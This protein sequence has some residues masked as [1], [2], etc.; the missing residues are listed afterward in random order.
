[1]SYPFQCYEEITHQGEAWDN[2]LNMVLSHEDE[3][4][5]FWEEREPTEV[6]F[7]GC[8]SPFYAGTSAARFWQATLGIPV[9]AV[10]CNE[11][12]QFSDS[13][14]AKGGR[15]ILVVLSRSGRTTEALWAVENFNKQYPDRSILITP[16]ENTPL[17]RLTKLNLISPKGDDEALPQ[18]RSVSSMY[19]SALAVG[20]ILGSSAGELSNLKQA[21]ASVD[22]ILPVVE[23]ALH[24]LLESKEFNRVFFLGAGPLDGIAREATLKVM[25][26]SFTD[27]FYY[28]FLESRHGPR[29][30]LDEQTLVVGMFS[31]TGLNYEAQVMQEYTQNFGVTSLAIVPTR[32]W[33]TGKVTQT[34][35]VDLALGDYLQ[36][37]IYLPV[38]QMVAFITA[39]NKGINPDLSKN[40]T[41]FIEISRL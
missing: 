36:G 41:T 35:S 10:P 11:L 27:A 34:V 15:P 38:V 3:I 1:M 24:K 29:S 30:L 31:K 39:V 14:I 7:T 26:M 5:A 18:T 8:T 20:A 4:K 28:P 2:T 9:R 19:F 16:R 40:T 37:L 23:P 21:A 32:P 13:Y 33:N 22:G 17:T 6:I 25:E 12:L